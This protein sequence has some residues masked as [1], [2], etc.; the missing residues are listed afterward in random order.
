MRSEDDDKS[1]GPPDKLETAVAWLGLADVMSDVWFLC[2]KY[3]LN[4]S[5]F[6][7]QYHTTG[8]ALFRAKFNSACFF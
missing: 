1:W 5:G 6:L 3:F 4:S 2:V 8:D 7:G